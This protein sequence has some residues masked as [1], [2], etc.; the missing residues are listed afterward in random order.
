MIKPAYLL[1]LLALAAARPLKAQLYLGVEGGWNKNHLTTGNASQSFTDYKDRSGF[2]AGIPV[3]Y[4]I[5]DW[6]AVQADPS[7]LQKNYRIERTGF[8][9]GVY[10]NNTNG[11][12]QLPLMAQLSFGGRQLRGFV[13]LGGYGAYWLSA[14]V[15]GTEPSVLNPVDTAYQTVNPVSVYG[16]NYPYSYDEKYS[17][18]SRRDRRME[19]GVLAGLGISYEWKATWLFFVEGRYTRALT[20]QQKAYQLNQT[21]R[22]ND[23]YG[24]LAGCL[25][26]LNRFIGHSI[27]KK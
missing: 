16:E 24:L 14:H 23:T 4:R 17:F 2:L 12:L 10:Q 26:R 20:D 25:F 21:P 19:W 27:S 22:Y 11:Y 1:L 9:N 6:L 3:L 15:R 18:D 13:N 7:Y 8:F 5:R